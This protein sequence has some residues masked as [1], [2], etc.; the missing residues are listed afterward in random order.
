MILVKNGTC[1]IWLDLIRFC[2]QNWNWNFFYFFFLSIC[3]YVVCKRDMWFSLQ[4][5]IYYLRAQNAKKIF[6]LNKLSLWFVNFSN[7]IHKS[8]LVSISFKSYINWIK[9]NKKIVNII[10]IFLF[11]KFTYC[12]III[13]HTKCVRILIISSTR[14]KCIYHIYI[15]ALVYI[16]LI[17]LF[18]FFFLHSFISNH[19]HII[20]E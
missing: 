14:I 9:K 15:Y 3:M 10:L 19:F 12:Y 1:E 5:I 17:I 6:L 11:S 8:L 20:K 18:S 7:I 4:S 2:S 16:F 13:W